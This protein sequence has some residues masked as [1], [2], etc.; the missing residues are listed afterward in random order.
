M[1]TLQLECP[2]RLSAPNASDEDVGP[3]AGGPSPH[4]VSPFFFQF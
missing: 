2:E 3:E 4:P 1:V